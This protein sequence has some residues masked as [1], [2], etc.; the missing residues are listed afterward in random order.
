MLDDFRRELR[1][2][3]EKF[4]QEEIAPLDE[5]ADQTNTF[6]DQLWRKLGDM[7][8]LGMTVEEEYGGTGLG[9]YE[10]CL[11]AEEISK[12]SG[13]VGLSYVA[14]SNLCMNQL[15]LNGSKY[16]KE[17]YLPKLCSGEYVGCLA[18]SE[19]GSGSDV[20]SMQLRVEDKGDR[21]VLNGTKMWITNAPRAD[22]I[23]VYAKS[24]PKN[25]K[26]M[27]TFLVEKGTK[28]FSVQ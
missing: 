1:E 9:Y 26:S 5:K 24:D 10:H 17:K 2:S 11:V 7:G 6:P 14:D 21:W 8:F 28:G 18:M 4:A 13:S 19:S 3:A 12:A 23:I 27:S 16:L 15:R 20:T 25:A 22:V